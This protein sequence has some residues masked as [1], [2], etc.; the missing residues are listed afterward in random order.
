[1]PIQEWFRLVNVGLSRAREYVVLIASRAEMQ[2][3]YLRPL[4]KYLKPRILK[5]SVSTFK[6]TEVPPAKI[7][8]IS[9][10]AADDTNLLAFHIT[11]CKAM[12]PVLSG[13][14]QRLCGYRM[15]GKPRLVRGV[16]GSGKT[17]VLAHWLAKTLGGLGPDVG[18][19]VWAVYA[20][21]AL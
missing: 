4:L 17:A 3:P 12:R 21:K 15:D 11:Q 19:K 2:S 8:E 18:G 9:E 5:Y 1:W 14:Q 13:E 16:A 7:Y 20:N 6:W 10:A